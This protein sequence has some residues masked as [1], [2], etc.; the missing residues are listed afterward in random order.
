M[1]PTTTMDLALQHTLQS[2][3]AVVS[4][5]PMDESRRTKVLP[6]LI[7]IFNDA[8]KGSQALAARSL[9]AAVQE[10]PALERFALFFRYL[11]K[12][13]GRDLPARLN[14]VVSVLS[15]IERN[16][17][18]SADARQRAADLIEQLLQAIVRENALTPLS[19]PKEL[20]LVF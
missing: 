18:V 1:H 13:I 7:Q 8:N 5:E 12:S 10:P 6:A 14:E 16:E 3:L 2:G 17:S 15:T 4:G 9:L 20:G 19:L 11:N